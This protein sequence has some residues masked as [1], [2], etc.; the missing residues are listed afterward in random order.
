VRRVLA[1]AIVALAAEAAAAPRESTIAVP[2]GW[3]ETPAPDLAAKLD[4]MRVELHATS[5]EVTLYRSATDAGGLLVFELRIPDHGPDRARIAA[6]E[7]GMASQIKGDHGR[8]VSNATAWVGD[9]LHVDQVDETE[10][11]RMHTKHRLAV[12]T[13]DVLHVTVAMCTAPAPVPA[14]EAALETVRLTVNDQAHLPDDHQSVAYWI[15]YV[16]GIAAVGFLVYI[17]TRKKTKPA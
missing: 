7:N 1:F 11:V 4:Q 6:F 9:Q 17:V 14:C 8:T 13:H 12:D 3:S 16:G 15:G 2:A 10:G 5:A